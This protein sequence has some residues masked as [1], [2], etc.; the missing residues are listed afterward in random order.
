MAGFKAVQRAEQYRAGNK[1]PGIAL[2]QKGSEIVHIGIL[3]K[4]GSMLL[5]PV[6]K[7]YPPVEKEADKR[8]HAMLAGVAGVEG[9]AMT[10]E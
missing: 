9:R 3:A 2:L 8:D 7:Y 1:Q 5:P 10:A 6:V 4:S